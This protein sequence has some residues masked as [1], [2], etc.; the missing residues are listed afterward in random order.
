MLLFSL[1]KMTCYLRATP[2]YFLEPFYL[3]NSFELEL[4]DLIELTVVEKVGR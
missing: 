1:K 2:I 4:V 3:V